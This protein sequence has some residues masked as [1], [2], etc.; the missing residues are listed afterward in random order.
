MSSADAALVEGAGG[1]SLKV[2][3]PNS[4]SMAVA[5]EEYTVEVGLCDDYTYML[6]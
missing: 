2:I 1:A 4:D 6:F 3:A 5:G